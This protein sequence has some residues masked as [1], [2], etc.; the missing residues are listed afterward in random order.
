MMNRTPFRMVAAA[1]PPPMHTRT[2]TAS[3]EL[4][5][6][7]VV[8]SDHMAPP[9]MVGSGDAAPPSPFVPCSHH[10]TA[11]NTSYP[12]TAS[13]WQLIFPELLTAFERAVRLTDQ[14]T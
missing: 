13:R 5:G 2:N 6:F 4:E 3:S 12:W 10:V 14:P 9:A 11:P 7:C 8:R 1:A